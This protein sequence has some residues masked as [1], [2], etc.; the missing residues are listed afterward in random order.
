MWGDVNHLLLHC[1][2]A[3][4]LWSLVMPHRVIKLF[5]SWQ[6]KFS[7]HCNI[8]ICKLM[9]HYWCGVF[10]ENRMLEFFRNVN[11]LY[12]RLSLFSFTLSS[13][14]VWFCHFFLFLLSYFS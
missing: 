3:Y 5:E 11:D 13:N 8:S 1:S 7:R 4:E 10:S 9:L 14:G 2:I 6:C 12:L